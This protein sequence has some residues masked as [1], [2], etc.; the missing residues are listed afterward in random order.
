MRSLRGFAS[1]V[2]LQV[3]NR[4]ARTHGIVA[5]FV[6]RTCDYA[7]PLS[8]PLTLTAV[9]GR[10]GISSQLPPANFEGASML[11]EG[12]DDMLCVVRVDVLPRCVNV[13]WQD[14]V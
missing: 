12:A 8:L 5:H 4:W 13:C 1:S 9:M 14:L 6:L 7:S 11:L 10:F 3:V 2:S